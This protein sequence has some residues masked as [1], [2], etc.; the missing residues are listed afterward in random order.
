MEVKKSNIEISE[1]LRIYSVQA[2]CVSLEFFS[3]CNSVSHINLIENIVTKC[4]LCRE[5]EGAQIL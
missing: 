3:Q 2:R 5:P 1:N 4:P